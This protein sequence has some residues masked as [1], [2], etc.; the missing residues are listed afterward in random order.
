MEDKLY[1]IGDFVLNEHYAYIVWLGS[2]RV[3]NPDFEEWLSKQKR[4]YEINKHS[5]ERSNDTIPI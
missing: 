2:F 3:D 5:K 4:Y 1:L